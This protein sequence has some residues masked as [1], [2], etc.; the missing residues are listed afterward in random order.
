VHQIRYV[1]C[2][3]CGSPRNPELTQPCPLCR[4]R[5]YPLI[6]YSYQHEARTLMV[7]GLIITSL[8]LLAVLVGAGVL[9]Y[10]E[11]GLNAL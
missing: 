4:S 7:M 6:G 11:M 2:D 8:T 9:V 10:L 1:I 5:K 3:H